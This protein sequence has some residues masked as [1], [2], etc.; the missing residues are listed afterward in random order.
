[1][2]PSSQG[3]IRTIAA[4]FDSRS[5]AEDAV[6]RLHSAGFASDAVRMTAGHQ[7]PPERDV[8]PDSHRGAYENNEGVGFWKL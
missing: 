3:Q 4:F 2:T 7:N 1:M 8:N 6:K 5:A